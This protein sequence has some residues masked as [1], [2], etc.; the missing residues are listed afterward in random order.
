MA[1]AD[2]KRL[3]P[4]HPH[5]HRLH[6]RHENPCMLSSIP[7]FAT[8]V[9]LTDNSTYLLKIC[10]NILLLLEEVQSYPILLYSVFYGNMRVTQRCCKAQGKR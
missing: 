1:T 3:C 5:Y 7:T 2:N 4:S 6:T 8:R 10:R 9:T